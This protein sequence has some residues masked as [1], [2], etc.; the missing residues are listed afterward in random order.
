[1]RAVVC[2]T[3]RPEAVDPSLRSPGLL[4]HEIAVPLPDAA[5]RREQLAVLTRGMPLAP[6]VRLDD[7][8]G[9]TPGFVAADLAALAREA[10]F[11][12]ALRQKEAESP[13]VTMADF[14]AA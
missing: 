7:V 8:A 13:T 12:A 6:D 14:E 4:D 2:T 3:S 1:G 11:R 5:L 10:G 9:R